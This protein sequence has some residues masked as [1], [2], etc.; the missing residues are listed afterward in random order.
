MKKREFPLDDLGEAEDQLRCTI[1]ALS[2]IADAID[3]S[4]NDG[5]SYANGLRA[6][7]SYFEKLT[8]DVRECFE[9]LLEKEG[10]PRTYD[11]RR[12]PP[13]VSGG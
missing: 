1:N 4:P 10:E 5:K 2:A 7:E 8:V 12:H 3:Y 13:A 6:I 11:N 9:A